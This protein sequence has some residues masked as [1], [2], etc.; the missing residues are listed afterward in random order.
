MTAV[1]AFL[2]ANPWARRSVIALAAV[3]AVWVGH[4]RGIAK[5]FD[6]G[7]ASMLTVMEAREREAAAAVAAVETK[8]REREKAHDQVVVQLRVEYAEATARAD[9]S[10]ARISRD[11]ANGSQRVR[12]QVASCSSPTPAPPGA[13]AARTDDPATAEL[14]GPIAAALWA[15]AVDGDQAIRQLTALQSWSRSAVDLCNPPP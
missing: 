15:I 11:L 2:W 1:L 3:A 4:R 12:I 6:Q 8:Y 5:G 13:S 7:A 14:P 10:D 9:A